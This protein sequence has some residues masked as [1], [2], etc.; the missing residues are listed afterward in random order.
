MFS[1]HSLPNLTKWL[2]ID[3]YNAFLECS[4]NICISKSFDLYMQLNFGFWQRIVYT[5]RYSH[6]DHLNGYKQLWESQNPGKVRTK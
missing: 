1:K 5:S 2:V 3:C 6:P 4:A